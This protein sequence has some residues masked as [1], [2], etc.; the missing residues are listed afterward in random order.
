MAGIRKTDLAGRLR[1][2][3]R[4]SR[5]SA[6]PASESPGPLQCLD[7]DLQ[8]FR[9]AALLFWDPR[10][11]AFAL[12]RNRCGLFLCPSRRGGIAWGGMDDLDDKSP[13]NPGRAE[14]GEPLPP[15]Q[16]S[17]PW[18][19]LKFVSF[20]PAIFPR[21]LGEVSRDARPGD[22]V[23][24]YDKFGHRVGTVADPD[25]RGAKMGHDVAHIDEV[26]R[27][28]AVAGDVDGAAVENPLGED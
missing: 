2:A 17:K 6:E 23:S 8:V 5:S 27:L 10:F 24:V 4:C 16:W 18:A 11:R 21:M 13:I 25:H 1:S 19:Q 22:L 14:R 9:I 28:H 12:F 3:I 26:A 20:Q 7:P 15:E